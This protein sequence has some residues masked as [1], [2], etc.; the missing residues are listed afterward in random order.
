MRAMSFSLIFPGS[1]Y[2][3]TIAVESGHQIG[4]R[5]LLKRQF[6]FEKKLDDQGGLPFKC[7]VRGLLQRQQYEKS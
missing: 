3:G 5:T 2:T 6:P 1:G 7:L 4:L